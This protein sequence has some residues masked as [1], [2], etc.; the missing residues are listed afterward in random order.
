MIEHFLLQGTDSCQGD[1]GGPLVVEEDGRFTLA[2]VVSLIKHIYFC[3]EYVKTVG[4][5]W[6][7]KAGVYARVTNYLDWINTNVAVSLCI[8]IK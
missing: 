5:I 4:V 3:C 6:T 2:G 1:S 7:G 8:N